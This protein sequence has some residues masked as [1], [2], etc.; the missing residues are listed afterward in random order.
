MKIRRAGRFWPLGATLVLRRI[1]LASSLAVL[2]TLVALATGTISM[3]AGASST[4]TLEQTARAAG[5]A[6]FALEPTVFPR[7]CVK[8]IVDLTHG[9]S[10]ADIVNQ[11]NQACFSPRVHKR[12][13]PSSSTAIAICGRPL[14]WRVSVASSAI[15][16]C[17]PG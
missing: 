11:M 14:A 3:G 8:R 13:G 2:A 4:P 17:S 16:G 5:P 9:W 10:E 12:P 15:L 7:H 6:V 1:E